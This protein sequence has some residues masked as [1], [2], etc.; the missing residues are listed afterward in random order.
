M[1]KRIVLSIIIVISM[2]TGC[3]SKEKGSQERKSIR[4]GI[5]VYDQ[6]DTFVSS[7]ID[8]L[9]QCAKI[10]EEE[11][12]IDITVDIVNASRSQL[13]QN[14]QVISYADK[15]YD[16]I[17]VNLVDRT[18]TSVI[19]DKVKSANIPII[20]FNRQLVEEDLER[21]NEL[22][23]VGAAAEDSGILQGNILIDLWEKNQK[24]IDKNKD[25]K[26]QYIMLEGEAG[27]QDALVRTEYSINTMIDSGIVVDKLDNGIANWNREQAANQMRIW[28][29]KYGNEI[30]VAIANNDDMALGVLDALR[31]L[32][33]KEEDYPI[34][35]GIDGTKEALN[36]LRAGNLVG[37]VLNDE[38]GQANGIIELAY[39]LAMDTKLPEDVYLVDKKY[40]RIPYQKVT[41]KNVDDIIEMV[42]R[43]RSE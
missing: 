18:D 32:E 36:E 31:S 11:T 23:Y 25:G 26:M 1:K 41:L 3:S 29:N 20:F 19:I 39:S 37:T 21:W 38:Y 15:N 28:W 9:N 22:Y 2:L 12:G 40:I 6:Y 33:V 7:L 17:C 24:E 34:I 10:K 42:N 16:I 8:A 14:E 30:E 13:T 27:H 4:I 35:V 5:S 43:N